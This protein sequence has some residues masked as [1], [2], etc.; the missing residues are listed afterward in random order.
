MMKKDKLLETAK[1]YVCGPR[2]ETYGSAHEN[3]GRIASLWSAY[4][5]CTV[6][7]AQVACMMVLMKMSR[8][9]KT[10]D[11]IDSWVDIAGY[12]ACGCEVST[13]QVKSTEAMAQCAMTQMDPFPANVFPRDYNV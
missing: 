11:H 1:S 9:D 6:S 13:E 2:E 4:L 3:F 7:P 12:A 5:G 10:P 8:L